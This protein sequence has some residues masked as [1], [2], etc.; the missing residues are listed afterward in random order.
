MKYLLSLS[1]LVTGLIVANSF[2]VKDP[3]KK[4]SPSKLKQ[5]VLSLMGDILE[6]E[7]QVLETSAKIQ[8]K[9]CKDIRAS[10]EGISASRPQLTK[11]NSLLSQEHQRLVQHKA[12]QQRFLS[13]LQ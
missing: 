9:L 10:L 12:A 2:I 6:L 7:S 1:V 5:E 8:Q 4:T 3:P 13:A 11:L